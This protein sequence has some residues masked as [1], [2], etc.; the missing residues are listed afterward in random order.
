ME[1]ESKYLVAWL[2]WCLQYWKGAK[3]IWPIHD[4][5][6]DQ[7]KMICHTNS[8]WIARQDSVEDINPISKSPGPPLPTWFNFN[9][10]MDKLS[11]TL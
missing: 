5:L 8:R 6:P 10:S 3:D 1:V 9:P 11:H 7:F 4:E 2:H